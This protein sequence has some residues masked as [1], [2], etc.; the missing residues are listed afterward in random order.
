[1][2]NNEKEFASMLLSKERK[3]WQD[4]LRICREIGVKKGMVVADLGCGPGFFT[5]PIASLVGPDGIVYAV[6]SNPVMLDILHKRI[7][8]SWKYGKA[9]HLINADVS[10]TGIKSGSVDLALFVNLLHD[11]EDKRAFL[12]EVKRIC[13]T[14]ANVVDIDW[15]KT[16]KDIGPPLK[17]RL[18]KQQ[19][20]NIMIRNGFKILRSI[21]AGPYHYGFVCKA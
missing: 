5:L 18:S 10:N 13:K 17:I 7:K 16:K 9:I 8:K 19:S 12:A 1:M 6:D 20:E 14:N 3:K 2:R 21:N 15:K 11:I 4:P